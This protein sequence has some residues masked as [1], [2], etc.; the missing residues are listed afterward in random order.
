MTNEAYGHVVKQ[1]IQLEIILNANCELKL[2][3]DALAE[4]FEKLTKDIL[5][6]EK[7]WEF[8]LLIQVCA[9]TH[10][11]YFMSRTLIKIV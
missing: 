9:K 5:I 6:I 3:R 7:D 4:E 10:F 8:L 1:N 2:K 11:T